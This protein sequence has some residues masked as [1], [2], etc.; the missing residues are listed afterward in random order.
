MSRTTF[1]ILVAGLAVAA[2]SQAS[3]LRAADEAAAP[4]PH[5]VERIADKMF[6]ALTPLSEQ[7]TPD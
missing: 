2:C 5:R 4:D 1:T 3:G 7:G 6:A